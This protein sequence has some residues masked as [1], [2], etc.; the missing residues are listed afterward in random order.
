[1]LRQWNCNWDSNRMRSF[2]LISLSSGSLW[3]HGLWVENDMGVCKRFK[4]QLTITKKLPIGTRKCSIL[5]IYLRNNNYRT[6]RLRAL[7]IL[8]FISLF[9]SKQNSCLCW[10]SMDFGCPTWSDNSSLY[11]GLTLCVNAYS[12]ATIHVLLQL[13]IC[14]LERAMAYC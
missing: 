4:S 2:Q 13:V 11:F 12:P 8:H 6:F 3:M 14:A 9:S 10:D 5:N 7:P 1:M